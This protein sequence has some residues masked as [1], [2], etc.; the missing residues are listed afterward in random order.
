MVACITGNPPD[1]RCAGWPSFSTKRAIDGYSC[2]SAVRMLNGMRKRREF[3]SALDWF[4]PC[5][6]TFRCE[7]PFVALSQ[8]GN[9]DCFLGNGLRCRR[10]SSLYLPGGGVSD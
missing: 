4:V 3:V 10:F 2:D 1:D 7:T 5:W 8:F 6:F 9:G